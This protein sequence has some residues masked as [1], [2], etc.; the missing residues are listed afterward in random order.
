M[1]LHEGAEEVLAGS[2]HSCD[3]LFGRAD[4]CGTGI[5]SSTIYLHIILDPLPGNWKIKTAVG[6]WC[7]Q[8]FFLAV[9]FVFAVEY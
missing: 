9:V 2:N 6:L 5:C 8:L 1:G 7:Q 3:A 4:C